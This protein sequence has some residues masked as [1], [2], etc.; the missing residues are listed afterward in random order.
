[1][2]QKNAQTFELTKIIFLEIKALESNL[3]TTNSCYNMTI[4][5]S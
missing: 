1:M 2:L 3:K 4:L 5:L